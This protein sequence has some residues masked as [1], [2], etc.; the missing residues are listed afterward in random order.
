[1]TRTTLLHS[2]ACLALS[3]TATT[4]FAQSEAGASDAANQ[5]AD[6]VVTGSARAE[7]RFDVSYAVNSLS[8]AEIQKLAPASMADLL[9]K[10]P[11]IQVEPTGGEV[12]NITRVRGIPTDGGYAYFQQDGL[13]L[14]HEGD[15]YFFRAADLQ[16]YDLMDARMETVRGGPAPIYASQAA[17]IVNNITVS[18]GEVSKGKAQL[19]LGTTGLYRLDLMQ[20]GK[21]G[22]RTYYAIGGFIRYNDGYR[23]NGF[24]NDKG[25]QIRANIKHDFDNG[26]IKITANYLN[27]HNVFYLPIPIADPRNPGTSL[28][29]YI[30]YFSGTMNSPALRNVNISYLD[31]SGARET[32]HR[33][34][35]NGRHMQFGN[36]GIQ[37]DGDFNGWIVSAKA[38]F[39]KGKLSFDAFYSTTNPVDGTTFANSYLGAARTAFGAGVD[40]I[41][42]AIAGTNGQTA[43]NPGADS[44]LVMQG[45]YRAVESSFYSGQADFSLTHKF[46]TGIGAHDVK[47]GL[48]ASAYGETLFSVY[49][50]YMVQVKGKPATLDMVAYSANNSVLG[51][52]TDNGALNDAST[53][54][55]G[56]V[57]A[58]MYA[59]YANDTW[60]IAK[61]L[62]V[63]AGIRHEGY[64][65]DGYA[66]LT[67]TANLGNASTLA[68]DATRRFN[69]SIQPHKLS[70]QITNWTVGANYD[71]T[72]NFGGYVRASHLEIPPTATV[73]ASVDPV[74]LTTKA[75]QFEAGLKASFGRSYLYLTGFY[76][77][78]N[79]YN[80]SFVAFNP[81]TGRNDQSVP[82]YGDVVVKGVEMDGALHIAGGLSVAGSLT[83]QSPKYQNLTNTSGADPSQVNGRQIIREPKLFGNI[84]PNYAFDMGGNHVEVYGT[85]SYTSKRYV[86]FFNQTALPAYG[87]FGVGLTAT[88]GTWQFQAVGDNITNA[89]GLTEGNTRT[90]IL[91]GQGTANAI[92]GRPLFGRNFRFILSK[93]W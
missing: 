54:S 72:R 83:V 58:K 18:G 23:D 43:Y 84:R 19:T 55:Q 11:G 53:L 21:L 12:Q 4:A 31:A 71:I 37:Y 15:G 80:A 93:S 63:D 16:R 35:G 41:G 73:A 25:G 30:N 13:P 56:N 91:S 76:T 70:P 68:D 34:L 86:D 22:D 90:D 5:P 40:H 1:M 61:G 26:S 89:H 8:Q 20:S 79:P 81:T 82:F 50:N 45:Q 46:E 87:M 38:G 78:F 49:Q 29:P 33:D 60:T 9:G 3:L 62:R 59:V 10:L 92:Y 88:R 2:C 6:I 64:T 7:R 27:D 77:K 47:V 51:Y 52:V 17:A 28:N 69:G 39:T 48:Y 36:L 14:F 42:Y 32:L 57:D 44:G 66:L 74:I 85:Y 24:P 75:N 67:S 65:F